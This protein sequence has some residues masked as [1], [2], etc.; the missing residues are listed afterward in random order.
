LGQFA[1]TGVAFR[2][3][4]VP[5]ALEETGYGGLATAG[6]GLGEPGICTPLV[7]QG[8]VVIGR[9]SKWDELKIGTEN[10]RD[11]EKGKGF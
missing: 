5:S 8:C 4:K 1:H 3:A 10:Q 7:D 11:K 2:I 9:F 6:G